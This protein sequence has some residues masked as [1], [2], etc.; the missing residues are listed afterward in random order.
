MP[1]T[2]GFTQTLYTPSTS[3]KQTINHTTN[4]EN[5]SQNIQLHNQSNHA[6]SITTHKSLKI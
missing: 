5:I 4:T 1:V 6:H 2:T 3:H